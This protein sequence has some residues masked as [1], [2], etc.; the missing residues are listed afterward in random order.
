MEFP[1]NWDHL[2]RD[3]QCQTW[4]RFQMASAFR[5]PKAHGLNNS[6][7]AAKMTRSEALLSA[8]SAF[9]V[10][11]CWVMLCKDSLLLCSPCIIVLIRMQDSVYPLKI[12]LPSFSLHDFGHIKYLQLYNS[13]MLIVG[14]CTRN[15]SLFASCRSALKTRTQTYQIGCREESRIP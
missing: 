12:V 6:S 5:F 4:F 11:W 14:S 13:L 15:M 9:C 8:C 7:G 10:G 1:H 2:A 3:Y